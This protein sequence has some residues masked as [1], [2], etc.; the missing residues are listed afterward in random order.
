MTSQQR[1]DELL[2]EL[3][4]HHE[5]SLKT[6]RS[7][8]AL[9][10]ANHATL[11]GTGNHTSRRRANSFFSCAAPE[12]DRGAG[13]SGGEV[14]LPGSPSLQATNVPIVPVPLSS[15][16]LRP[17][18]HT[19]SIDS[20]HLSVHSPLAVTDLG[21]MQGGAH[22]PV[23]LYSNESDAEEETEFIPLLPLVDPRQARLQHSVPVPAPVPVAVPPRSSP[24][25]G[26]IESAQTLLPSRSFSGEQLVRHVQNLDEGRAGTLIALLDDTWRRRSELDEARLLATREDELY[27][28]ATYEVYDVGKD[29][30]A[31]PQH[32]DRGS[33]NDGAL[34]LETVWNTVRDINTITVRQ[35]KGPVS[36]AG[37]AVGRMTI[38]QEPS[39]IMLSTA[40]LTMAEHFDM[41]ELIQH[42]VTPQGNKGKTRAYM[43]HR[44]FELSEV[45]QRSFFFVFKYYTAVGEGLNPA[46]YQ[47]YDRRP[48]DDKAP[49]HIEITECS[50]VLALSLGGPPVSPI[51][52]RARRRRGY[53]AGNVFGHFAPWHLLSIQ[54][55]ADNEHSMRSDDAKKPF[56]SGPYAFL[57]SLA[58]EYRDAAKR[59]ALLNEKITKLITP[60]SQFMFE[61][62]LRDKLLFEDKYFTYS[63]RYFWA[64][65]S[66]A[67]INDG[68]KSMIAVYGDTFD[69]DFWEGR[70]RTLW[71]LPPVGEEEGEEGV[72]AEARRNYLDKMAAL[73]EELKRTMHELWAVHHRNEALRK[74]IK[75][76]REQLFSG[77]SVKE[78]RR[79]IE[80]GDNIK[81]LTSVSM[82]F[83]PLTFVTSVFGITNFDLSPK[84]WQFVTTMLCVC[85]PFFV[86]IVVL[87]TQAGMEMCK[88][89]GGSLKGYFQGEDEQT[90]HRREL[91]S[92]A[93][94]VDEGV[95]MATRA[96]TVEGGGGGEGGGGNGKKQPLLFGRRKKAELGGGPAVVTAAAAAAGDDDVEAARGSSIRGGW[97]WGWRRV[98]FGW[99]SRIKSA[100]ENV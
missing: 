45:R 54:S 44:A 67:L 8:E 23:S 88:R 24:Q 43:Q 89:L 84:D 17:I 34:D 14:L 91:Q 42:L 32:D 87:Q 58:A 27:G 46:P 75:S 60:S 76:L 83:L 1:Q 73:R 98:F 11:A 71:P 41:D 25:D 39:P 62:K 78:S 22:I 48:P 7:L 92:L 72:S 30:V 77:S 95:R 3:Q 10:A 38:L 31:T 94:R 18:T 50:S 35:D 97:L 19:L 4:R 68:I 63:R 40:H 99:Q 96:A 2:R 66:L 49:D 85:V 12:M 69:A 93:G 28:S 6:L 81:I 52:M 36:S 15:S 90:K 70:H 57:D 16:P 33:T 55:F 20:Q 26:E 37:G 82:I 53:R 21:V 47:Q 64:Y 56:Y 51:Y 29:S 80:Q 5:E 13:S 9:A 59:Y 65:N 74:E 79:A 61:V 100:D 86:L